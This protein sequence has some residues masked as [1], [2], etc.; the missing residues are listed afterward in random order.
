[1]RRRECSVGVVG[2]R[3]SNPLY[4]P[5][6]TAA[7]L[8][9]FELW[10]LRD[11]GNSLAHG[12]VK[13]RD[14]S[15]MIRCC[16]PNRVVAAAKA[17]NCCNDLGV[18]SS[19]FTTYP[20]VAGWVAKERIAAKRASKRPFGGDAR[21]IPLPPCC[22]N[23]ACRACIAS[24]S[25]QQLNQMDPETRQLYAMWRGFVRHNQDGVTLP[26]VKEALDN[27][28]THLPPDEVDEVFSRYDADGGGFLD[29]DEFCG[30]LDDLR[31][32]D[33]IV[34]RRVTSYQLPPELAK[35]MD[36]E[37]VAQLTLAFGQFDTSG[38]G[39]LDLD[40]F[41]GAMRSLGHDLTDDEFKYRRRAGPSPSRGRRARSD[42][43]N[44]RGISASWERG[45]RDLVPAEYPRRG[46]GAAA[47]CQRNHERRTYGREIAPRPQGTC[48]VWS[49]RTGRLPSTL[50][51]SATSWARWSTASCS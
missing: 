22:S 42:A 36:D 27:H 7:A 41:S 34:A 29:F 50:G 26:G 40:E 39:L 46:R 5:N 28:G 38:D 49:T 43:G 14:V 17:R 1:M 15:K 16:F 21:R 4:L 33:K 45:H 24:L 31:V 25:P 48:S 23:P 47:I 51:S 30:M 2:A 6:H 35:T 11:V 13:R 12:I 37:Q 19:R 20:A 9:E 3:H 10:A 44:P 8:E 32:G 18:T